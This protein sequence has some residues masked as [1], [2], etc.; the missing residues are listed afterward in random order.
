VT[1]LETYIGKEVAVDLSDG[2]TVYGTLVSADAHHC[3]FADADLHIQ[4]EANSTRDLYAKEVSEVGV[5]PNRRRL[6]VP[7]GRVVGICLLE[8]LAP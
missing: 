5:R 2:F 4:Q 3:V 8:D 6:A 1:W 7:L